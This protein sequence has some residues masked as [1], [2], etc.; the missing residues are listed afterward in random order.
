[1]STLNHDTVNLEEERTVIRLFEHLC[2]LKP[3]FFRYSACAKMSNLWWSAPYALAQI[4]M[5]N[6]LDCTSL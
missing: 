6:V 3:L 5:F 4:F 1:M 2:F